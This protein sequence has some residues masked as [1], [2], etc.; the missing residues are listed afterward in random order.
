MQR[1][2][3]GAVLRISALV[4]VGAAEIGQHMAIAPALGTLFFPAIKIARVAA[5][6][7]HPVDR[8]RTTQHLAARRG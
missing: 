3:A 4:G 8:G 7:N 1:T 5:Y 6:P 2:I